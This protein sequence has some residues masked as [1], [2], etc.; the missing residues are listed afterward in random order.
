[1]RLRRDTTL[2]NPGFLEQKAMA[3]QAPPGS[4]KVT[5]GA[6]AEYLFYEVPGIDSL[7]AA[8]ILAQT[9]PGHLTG[10]Q[11]LSRQ[12]VLDEHSTYQVSA[13]AVVFPSGVH[14]LRK[15]LIVPAGRQLILEAG[16]DIR[17]YNGA[18]LL[19]YSPLQALGTEDHPVRISAPNRDGGG[20]AVFGAPLPSS[21]AYLVAEGLDAPQYKG[22]S[23]TGAVNFY[24]SEVRMHNSAILQNRS[25][26]ALN[27]IRSEFKLERCYIGETFSDGFDA[28]FCKGEVVACRIE[29]T[30]NDGLDFSGSTVTVRD[31]QLKGNGDKGISV[32]E[33]SDVTVFGTRI[34]GAPIGVASKDLSVLRVRDLS[35]IDCRQGFVAYQ[36][37]PEF[38]PG[39]IIVESHQAEGVDRL[40]NIAE[41][42]TLLGL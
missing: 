15:T 41:G 30:G 21:V 1:M 16:A 28:D 2:R 19:S 24:E 4:T 23:L 38:G 5:V 32:G 26:D 10:R 20:M 3:V 13:D 34:K 17:L 37:K 18:S 22:W 25:E 8:P 7:F 33:E 29:N 27:I 12:A 14:E 39:T 36:K 31:C 42:N 35:L 6:A 9:P 40:T 11:L